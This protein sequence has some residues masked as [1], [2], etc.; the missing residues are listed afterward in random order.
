MGNYT[1]TTRMC[2]NEFQTIKITVHR[3][4]YWEGNFILKKSEMFQS[5]AQKN[6]IRIDEVKHNLVENQS[7]LK[8]QMNNFSDKTRVHVYAQQFQNNFPDSLRD[9][10]ELALVS[11]IGVTSF[12]FVLWKNMFISN[13]EIG[14]EIRYVFDRQK[15][16]NLMG[17]TLDKPTLLMKKQFVRNTETKNEVL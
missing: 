7:N 1:L 12:P 3:G 6:M 13:N 15:K 16:D 5:S 4:Q 10:I 2:A 9:E 14:D 11:E 17:N 8:I